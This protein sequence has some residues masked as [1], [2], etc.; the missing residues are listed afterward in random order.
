MS[1]TGVALIKITARA[2]DS[3]ARGSISDAVVV[4]TAYGAL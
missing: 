3:R 4:G 2:S 1:G